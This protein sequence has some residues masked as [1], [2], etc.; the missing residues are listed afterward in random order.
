[1]KAAI[2]AFIKARLRRAKLVDDQAPLYQRILL[3]RWSIADP[4]N[5]INQLVRLELAVRFGFEL[6][7]GPQ[8]LA[9]PARPVVSEQ[10]LYVFVAGDKRVER[11]FAGDGGLEEE[12]GGLQHG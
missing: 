4:K 3:G 7:L 11:R 9:L 12:R 5:E 1:M 6:E 8:P 10:L 2:G